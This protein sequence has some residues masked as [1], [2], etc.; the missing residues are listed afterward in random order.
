VKVGC[1]M[2]GGRQRWCGFNASIS[3]QDERRRD[4]ALPEDKAEAVRSYWLYR[5]EA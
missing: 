3:A 1:Y 5:K 4:E 2:E